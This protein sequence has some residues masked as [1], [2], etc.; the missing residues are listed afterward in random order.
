MEIYGKI[1]PFNVCLVIPTYNSWNITATTVR[2][3]L[4][5]QTYKD[6][7]IVIVDAGS[8]DYLQLHQMLAAKWQKAKIILI[9]TD[10]DLGGSGSFYLGINI[11]LNKLK[12]GIVILADNDAKPLTSTLIERLVKEVESKDMVIARPRNYNYD[13]P[14]WFLFH[15]LTIPRKC[16]EKVDLSKIKDYFLHDDDYALI[17][18]LKLVGCDMITVDEYYSH[19]MTFPRLYYSVRNTVFQ[20]LFRPSYK[21]RLSEVIAT[22]LASFIQA[23]YI[24]SI[25]AFKALIAGFLHGIMGRL[26]QGPK[27][28]AKIGLTRCKAT[29][30]NLANVFIHASR[31]KPK[32]KNIRSREYLTYKAFI[33]RNP[34]QILKS[35]LRYT[36][37]AI[38][39]DSGFSLFSILLMISN[40]VLFVVVDPSTEECEVC[41][42]RM[43]IVNRF[44][45]S[46][47]ILFILLL[48]VLLILFA[49]FKLKLIRTV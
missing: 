41:T 34:I 16:L 14:N 23:M 19:P 33:S 31:E 45:A 44:L 37:K 43:K 6:I 42:Y 27:D 7:T 8:K 38:A 9:H 32:C 40:R 17:A 11:C 5:K 2:E 47:M 12:C 3:I 39:I 13:V 26:G 29:S 22:F 46:V 1:V 10:A 28:V 49:K 21:I 24:G 20:Y 15:F 25:R 4:E 48:V 36:N 30:F 18:E 35:L